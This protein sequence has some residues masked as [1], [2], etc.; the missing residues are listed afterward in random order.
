MPN[1]VRWVQIA[2]ALTRIGAVLVPLSTLLQRRANS[3]RSCGSPSVQ[4]LVAVEEFRGH[5]YLDDLKSECQPPTEL[6]ALRSVWTPDQLPHATPATT[7]TVDAIAAT[8]T[9][10][11]HAGHHVHLGK[12]RTAEGRHP[13]ARQRAG[14]RAVRPGGALHRRR[15]P[16]VPADAVLLGGRLRQRHPVGAAG[17]RHAGHRGD[18]AA[19]DHA[20]AAGARARHAVPRLARPGRSPCPP[21]GLGRRRSVRAAAGQPGGAAAARAAGRSRARGPRCSG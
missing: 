15:H 3:S 1:G 18:P 19:R 21:I 7:A 13:L 9:R 14:R 5:R 12:Q 8:V 2:I 10:R 16:A 11:R 4:Y 6:P 17:G 20:A